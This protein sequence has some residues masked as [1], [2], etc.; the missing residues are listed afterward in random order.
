MLR[1]MSSN[2][3]KSCVQYPLL[4]SQTFKVCVLSTEKQLLPQHIAIVMDG[5]GRWAKQ[6]GKVRLK[7][8]AAG[9]KAAKAVISHA[10]SIKINCL[11]L[12]SFS[13]ENWMR[14]KQEVSFLMGLFVETLA[15][16][17]AEL[18]NNN[19]KIVFSGSREQLSDK[20]CTIM[21]QA[22]QKTQNNSGMTLNI[23][24]NYGG[25]WDIVE[26]TKS[27]ADSIRSNQ[28]KPDDIDEALLGERLCLAGLP[29]PDLFIRTSGEFRISNFFLWQ[30]A[31]SE[32]YFCD[33]LWPD[34][35]CE[36]FDKALTWFA[37]RERRFG[38]T[39]AQL[40]QTGEQHA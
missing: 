5:N 13:S 38:K 10:A 31:Y 19:I 18:H 14:P 39:S 16:E 7:G 27:I 36:A 9:A 34:F 6:R 17:L 33:N 2:I 40:A 28:L 1:N 26:A 4:K 25:R 15:K 21:D 30:L 12:F 35:D 11:S 32:L 29:E 24:F 23:V 8:H 37:R 3:V 22:T 20:L